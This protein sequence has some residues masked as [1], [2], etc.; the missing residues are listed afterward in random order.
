M[1]NLRITPVAEVS[2]V[3]RCQ[4]C[5]ETINL[6]ARQCPFCSVPIDAR[7]AEAAADLMERVNLACSQAFGIRTM[8]DQGGT[9][10]RAANT[11]PWRHFA[12]FWLLGSATIYA[13][14]LAESLGF[15]YELSA[16]GFPLLIILFI[17]FKRF[18]RLCAF[19]WGIRAKAVTIPG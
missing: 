18:L 6:S 12:S 17:F 3:F 19:A 5:K 15:G 8:F 7:T 10:P 1:N 14:Y 9:D 4:H 16:I 13:I 11:T 2:R